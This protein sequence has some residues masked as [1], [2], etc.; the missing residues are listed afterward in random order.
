MFTL[1]SATPA[2]MTSVD[3]SLTLNSSDLPSDWVRAA[4]EA[5]LYVQTVAK[6]IAQ[7]NGLDITDPSLYGSQEWYESLTA[8]ISKYADFV[9][10]SGD[11]N[12]QV[13]DSTHSGSLN[14]SAIMGS[15]MTLYL[16]PAAA[17]E[18]STLNELLGNAS[19][20]GV[21]D[22]MN[23]W[24]SHVA[25]S[26]TDTGLSVG[27]NVRTDDSQIQWAVCYYSMTHV[28]DDW[29]SLFVSSTYEEFDVKAAGLTLTM[30]YDTYIRYAEEP[31]QKYL[32][33]DIADK[34]HTAPVP[35]ATVLGTSRSSRILNA[36]RPVLDKVQVT[37]TIQDVNVMDPTGEPMLNGAGIGDITLNGPDVQGLRCGVFTKPRPQVGKKYVVSGTYDDTN[38]PFKYTLQC[39]Q[40]GQQSSFAP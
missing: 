32:G 33:K 21:S 8:A 3:D 35:K 11:K 9:E 14:L 13:N 20:P 38:L 24:W 19:D 18:W 6:A 12:V 5:H 40:T 29:R 31:V 30:N 4:S 22:F 36:P 16:G 28:I 27:P 26:T 1:Q 39:R 37:R 7:Q 17:A 15:I 25:K 10:I 2:S 23:F 34:I